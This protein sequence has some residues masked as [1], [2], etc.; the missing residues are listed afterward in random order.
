MPS[1]P[2]L[3]EERRSTPAPIPRKMRTKARID[4]SA[5]GQSTPRPSPTQNRPNAESMTP[6]ANLSAFSGTWD[7]GLCASA[8]IA[9]TRTAAESAPRLAGHSM[10][11]PAP[12]AITMKT[13]SVPSMSTALN[14][15]SP[16]IQSRLSDLRCSAALSSRVCATNAASSSCS[17]MRPIERKI[18]LRSQRRP[19][20]S[21]SAADDELKRPQ[22]NE[23]EHRP[24]NNDHDRQRRNA[25][26]RPEERRAASRAQAIP[27]ERW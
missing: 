4:R 13:T 20:R 17:A 27:R 5:P 14:A 7:R 19:N 9:S 1:L 26:E 16:A 24:E 23:I 12:T 6:T 3:G 21:S 2:I 11:L 18:A 10:P 22:R 8:P 25:D 15:A